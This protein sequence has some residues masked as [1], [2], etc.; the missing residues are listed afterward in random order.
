M[1]SIAR[2]R[3]IERVSDYRSAA[4]QAIA[5]LDGVIIFDLAKHLCDTDRCNGIVDDTVIYRDSNHLNYFGSLYV[6]R[7]FD[8]EAPVLNAEGN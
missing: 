2:S 3:Y 8:W 5:G 4:E 1:C 7:F 6:S